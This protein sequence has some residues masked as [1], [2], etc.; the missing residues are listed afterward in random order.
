MSPLASCEHDALERLATLLR[1]R[2]CVALTGAGCSTE[3]GIPDYRGA[4]RPAR[5]TSPIQHGAF[6][7]DPLVRRRYWARAALG[8]Q[9]FSEARPN[10]A[11]QAL[12]A[13]ER[14]GVVTGVITQ[15]VDRL[16]QAAGS[17]RVVELH[18]ALAE[19]I[20]LDCGARERRAHMQTRLVDE[21][22]GWLDH[23][24]AVRPDG[25]ADLP[26]AHL[27]EFRVV[28][29]KSCG[30]TLKPDVVFFGG[31]VAPPVLASA[32]AL[33]EE[34]TTLLVV[35]S[36]LAVFSGFRFARRAAET[37]VRLA[38][39]NVGPSRADPLG[40][41]A[42]VDGRAGDALSYVADRLGCGAE[43]REI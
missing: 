29:C 9:K 16:H 6:L 42:R 35:G 21:N 41:H 14:A 24:A 34:A 13:L 8:W 22:P 18:G 17:A 25:D 15:N 7:R 3:S 19:V 26:A 38:I 36:S 30:G 23:A 1:E 39:V 10:R 28:G 2:R 43:A 5:P 32:W 4:G 27:A 12:A 11:H 40:P 31:S 37:G 20:C 33:F